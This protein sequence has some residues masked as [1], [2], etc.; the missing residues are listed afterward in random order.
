MKVRPNIKERVKL[1]LLD[2]NTVTDKIKNLQSDTAPFDVLLFYNER[3]GLVKNYLSKN[4]YNLEVPDYDRDNVPA[5]WWYRGTEGLLRANI[6]NRQYTLLQK[7]EWIKCALNPVYF[8]K[9]HVKIIS[10]DEGI[11]PFELRDY[12]E[13]IVNLYDTERFA[14]L[15]MCRQSGKTTTSGAYLCH[16]MVFFNNYVGIVAQMAGQAQEILE[17]IQMA[18]ELM[19]LYLQPGV[20]TYNK[21]SFQL[22]NTSKALAAASTST[23]IRG[24]SFSIVLIDEASHLRRDMEFY[25]SVY[26]TISSGKHSRVYVASTPNGMRG[27]FY[28]LWK[29]AL[30][31]IN[32]FVPMQIIWSDVPGRDEE[33]RRETIANTS[34]EQFAQEQEVQF[35]GSQKSLLNSKTLESLLRKKPILHTEEG[36]KVY[37]EPI[38]NHEYL[39]TVDVS[40]GVGGDNHSFSIVDISEEIHQVV[41]TFKNNTM[42]TLY[43]PHFIHQYATHYNAAFVLVEINDIGEQVANTL[44]YDLEYEN[45][46][47]TVSEKGKQ[48][49]GFGGGNDLRMGVRTDKKVKPIGCSNIKTFIQN[50]RIE[51]NDEGIINE[52][53]TFVPKGGSFAADS[54]ATDDQVMTMVLYGWAMT[55][56]YFMDLANQDARKKIIERIQQERDD[57][58]MPFGIIDNGVHDAFTGEVDQYE[59]F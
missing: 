1:S 24:K 58:I 13:D 53:G 48:S 9:K 23:T 40:R 25:E 3:K 22:G 30:E 51:L 54:G 29:E 38:K 57:D 10:I 34:E 45:L 33:W 50:G 21:R 59:G 52:F 44:Y 49:I 36:I 16:Q 42:S 5:H 28:K 7:L 20:K 31:G 4:T 43:Y 26:P 37:K 6:K 12:Q 11:V 47:T 15:N 27:L 18:Y 56:P 55:Q 32:S 14:I 41:C 19:P 39:M 2:A 46:L 17:R 8:I 35:M